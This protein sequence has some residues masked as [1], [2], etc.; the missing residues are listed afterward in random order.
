MTPMIQMVEE[1]LDLLVAILILWVDMVQEI[2]MMRMV[3]LADPDLAP[4]LIPMILTIEKDLLM[5]P[6]T[7]MEE[8]VPTL[9]KMT[10][11]LWVDV[12]QEMTSMMMMTL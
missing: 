11:I 10:Q 8:E 6:T 3:H 4:N 9:T 12:V 5:I 7:R 1:V 2:M